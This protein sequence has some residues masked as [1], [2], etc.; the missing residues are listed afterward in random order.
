[1]TIEETGRGVM[2]PWIHFQHAIY[3]EGR[4]VLHFPGRYVEILGERLMG[5]WVELQQQ[6][7]ATIRRSGGAQT[8]GC[9]IHSL[10]VIVEDDDRRDQLPLL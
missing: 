8:G 5:L 7:I 1:M 3:Q 2:L 6:N 4:I 9:T 10:Q